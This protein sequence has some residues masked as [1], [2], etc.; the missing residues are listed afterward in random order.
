MDAFY[1]RK[2]NAAQYNYTTMKKELLSVVMTLQE[3]HTMLFGAKL[4]FFTDQ[5]NLTHIS[6]LKFAAC[7]ALAQFLEAYSP[8]FKCIKSPNN[9]IVDAFS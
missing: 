6:Q 3:F 9:V 4:T 5:K 7:C 8:T 2:L 1:W